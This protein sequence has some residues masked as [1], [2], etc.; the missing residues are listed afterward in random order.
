M[1]IN[2]STDI[3]FSVSTTATVHI[4]TSAHITSPKPDKLQLTVG[5]TL[6]RFM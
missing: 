5:R 2:G 3:L 6:S 4:N 1:G